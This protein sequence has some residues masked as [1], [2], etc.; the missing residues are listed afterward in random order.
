M[1]G[2]ALCGAGTWAWGLYQASLSEQGVWLLRLAQSQARMIESVAQF[3][4]LHSQQDHPLGAWGATISQVQAAHNDQSAFGDTGEVVVARRAGDL[5]VFLLKQRFSNQDTRDPIPFASGPAEPMRNALMGRSGTM[6]GVDYRNVEVLAAYEPL[7]GLNAGIVAK[8]DLSEIRAPFIK[9]TILGGLSTLFIVLIGAGLTKIISAPL[10]TALNTAVEEAKNANRVKSEFLASMSHELRTPLNAILGFAQLMKYDPNEKLAQKHEDYANNIILGGEHLLELINDVLDLARIEA[11]NMT[12]SMEHIYPDRVIDQCIKMIAPVAKVRG[13]QI[14]NRT[15]DRASSS[16]RADA[17]RLKQVLINLINNAV[18]YNVDGGE[19]VLDSR[20][21]DDGYL[22]I[23][24]ADR[25]IGIAQKDHK[26]V[27]NVFHRLND[28][29]MKTTEGTGIGLTVS[30]HMV[31]QMGGRIDFESE[32]GQGSTFWIDLPL[33]SKFGVLVWE[34]ELAVGIDAIDADHKMLIVM[35][36]KLTDQIL[37]KGDLD[38]ILTELVNHTLSHFRRE[39]VAMEICAYPRLVQHRAAHRQLEQDVSRF[40]TRW[41][42]HR[43]PQITLELL[44]FVRGWLLNHI[45]KEDAAMAPYVKAKKA[46]IDQ[47][48]ATDKSLKTG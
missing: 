41:R 26:A 25:G 40:V 7:K 18:K 16:I 11:D 33:E 19:V 12:L 37:M 6:I 22:R 29:P 23:S 9:F 42:E 44:S 38:D 32:L 48:L 20:E 21:T 39:E 4:A 24:V 46:E 2:A 31:E 3:D 43:D 17:L 36:D 30:K 15:T 28:D 34:D 8:I 47:A 1:V 27:F 35:L 13:I 5:I 10:V 14:V 45:L